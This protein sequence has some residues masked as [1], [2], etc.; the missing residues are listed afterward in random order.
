MIALTRIMTVVIFA[1]IAFVLIVPLAIRRH[2]T[3][4]AVGIS[5]LFVFYLAANVVLWRRMNRRS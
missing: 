1:A 4:I 2:Q 5:V 3:A